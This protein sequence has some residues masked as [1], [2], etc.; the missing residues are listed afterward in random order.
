MTA[1]TELTLFSRE[2]NQTPPAG[3]Y[4]PCVV[5]LRSGAVAQASWLCVTG[6][7]SYDMVDKHSFYHKTNGSNGRMLID[8]GDVIAFMV[9]PTSR[10]QITVKL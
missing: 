10:H 9:L 4:R 1:K 8:D 5:L 2:M 6:G 3:G 7:P